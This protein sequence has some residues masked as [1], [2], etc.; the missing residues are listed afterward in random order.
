[1]GDNEKPLVVSA[2]L[3]ALSNNEFS[4][5][6]LTGSKSNTDGKKIFTAIRDYMSQVEVTPDTK[7][8][9]P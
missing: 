5:E 4:I 2:I 8:K 7:K 6:Q 1:M 3:L 9:S